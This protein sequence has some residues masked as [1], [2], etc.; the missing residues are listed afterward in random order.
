MNE[1]SEGV[2]AGCLAQ[3]GLGLRIFAEE[4]SEEMHLRTLDININSVDKYD[5]I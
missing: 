5:N 3:T 1:K 4:G 2:I